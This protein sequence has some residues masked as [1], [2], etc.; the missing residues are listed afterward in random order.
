MAGAGV[1]ARCKVSEP[2]HFT[3]KEWAGALADEL[4]A[5]E[6][7]GEP[8]AA[9]ARSGPGTDQQDRRIRC[10]CLGLLIR[11]RHSGQKQRHTHSRNFDNRFNFDADIEGQR[12]H[13]D[14]TACMPPTVAEYLD[15]KS[16]TR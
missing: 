2:G 6:N 7:R 3:W 4:K 9:H 13:S 10:H 11:T 8:D 15:K 1:C 16:A 14:G 12:T 5:A